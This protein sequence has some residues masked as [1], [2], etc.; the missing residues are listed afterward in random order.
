MQMKSE[1]IGECS[2]KIYF[3][4]CPAK[5]IYSK[6]RG[7]EFPTQNAQMEIGLGT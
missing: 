2:T 1:E 5:K 3:K 7:I 6:Q 4:V